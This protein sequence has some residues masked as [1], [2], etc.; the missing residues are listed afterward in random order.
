MVCRREE[1]RRQNVERQLEAA[2]EALSLCQAELESGALYHVC[3]VSMSA[4][5][6]VFVFCLPPSVSRSVST[7]ACRS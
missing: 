6:P 5:V 7:D 3:V 1:Q 2:K 4:A